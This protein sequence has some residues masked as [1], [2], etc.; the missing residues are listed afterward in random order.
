MAAKPA[1]SRVP[2]LKLLKLISCSSVINDEHD[3]GA[4]ATS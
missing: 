4:F 2:I 3:Y 1:P